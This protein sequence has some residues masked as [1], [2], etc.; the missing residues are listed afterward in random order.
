[1]TNFSDGFPMV[2]KDDDIKILIRMENLI[3]MNENL[4]FDDEGYGYNE[5]AKCDKG[6]FLDFMTLIENILLERSRKMNSESGDA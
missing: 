4:L 1:M 5:K 3:G 2:I 6:E